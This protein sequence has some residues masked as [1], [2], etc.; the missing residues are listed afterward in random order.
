MSYTLKCKV[1][2]FVLWLAFVLCGLPVTVYAGQRTVDIIS[3]AEYAGPV[4]LF[5]SIIA[6]GVTATFIPTSIDP[7]LNHP[8][9]AK[10]FIGISFGIVASIF[11][12][13]RLNL[14]D[15]QLFLPAY[16]LASAGTPMMVYAIGIASDAETYRNAWDA[17]RKKIWMGRK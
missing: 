5:F 13:A 1:R 9:I 15:L 8:L 7:Q 4:I 11:I 10:I 3:T 14:D 2:A 16:F 12:S 6:G 17:I